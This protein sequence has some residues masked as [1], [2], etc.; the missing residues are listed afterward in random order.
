MIPAT[1]AITTPIICIHKP[2]D[3]PVLLKSNRR[4]DDPLA[5][6]P[7]IRNSP[8]TMTMS[9]VHHDRTKITKASGISKMKKTGGTFGYGT[10]EIIC[11]T[12]PSAATISPVMIV[13]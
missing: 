2:R 8:A 9:D 12:M 5:K 3:P 7:M 11:N 13:V 10:P 1:V 4:E 6:S